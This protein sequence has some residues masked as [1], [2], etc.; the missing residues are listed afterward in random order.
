MRRVRDG[1]DRAA[2]SLAA[3]LLRWLT[4]R[5]VSSTASP[6]I[7][8]LTAEM[9]EIGSGRSR[10]VWALGG[11]GLLIRQR[12]WN[13]GRRWRVRL[14][15]VGS[16]GGL[17]GLR[18]YLP[19]VAAGLLMAV[20]SYGYRDAD[21]PVPVLAALLLTPYYVVVGLWWGRRGRVETAA[22]VGAVTAFTGFEIYVISMAILIAATESGLNALTWLGF[23][24][25]FALL[26]ALVGAFCG[27]IGGTLAHPAAILRSIHR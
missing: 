4:A 8:A 13:T 7:D 19:A 14:C 26:V 3:W 10:L 27:L 20:W 6:W 15:W 2:G 18:V 22:L 23:G 24:L 9:G 11:A 16:A 21:A 25:G 5:G 17:G 12:L 1:V